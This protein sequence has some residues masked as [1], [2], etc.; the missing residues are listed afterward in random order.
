L[1]GTIRNVLVAVAVGLVAAV[2]VGCPSAS[3]G[4]GGG[5]GGGA[6][7]TYYIGDNG[8]AGGIIFFDDEDN[9][10]DDYGFRYLE[11]APVSSELVSQ[12]GGVSYDVNE[13]DDTVAPELDGV[14]DGQANTTAI[15]KELGNNGGT[16]YA[17]KLADDLVWGGYRDWF[18]PSKDELALMY[19]NLH[20]Q[21]HG[22]FAAG[23]YWSSSES[24]RDLAWGQDFSTGAGGNGTKDSAI[25]LR[26]ARAFG[27]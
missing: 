13:D 21:R 11:A 12:W 25:R 10:R 17:A 3:A 1:G 8:P 24:D 27:D 14:G 18:L 20:Q 4:G 9:G 23:V 7:T 19:L 2:L 16:L 22:G 6:T 5:N 26:A 15:I